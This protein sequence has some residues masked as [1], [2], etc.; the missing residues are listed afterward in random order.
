ML[1]DHLQGELYLLT[2]MRQ[3]V[4]LKDIKKKNAENNSKAALVTVQQ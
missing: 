4:S 2:S 3:C 1:L